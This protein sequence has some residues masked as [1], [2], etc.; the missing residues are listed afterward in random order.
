[1]YIS[2]WLGEW[3]I[4]FFFVLT[5]GNSIYISFVWEVMNEWTIIQSKQLD[6][7]NAKIIVN[8]HDKKKKEKKK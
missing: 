6:Q 2:E 4:F 7:E 8:L 1:M 5:L 3:L